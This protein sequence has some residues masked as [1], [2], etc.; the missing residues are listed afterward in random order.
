MVFKNELL[1]KSGLW[2]LAFRMAVQENSRPRVHGWVVWVASVTSRTLWKCR[3]VTPSGRP[4]NTLDCLL[5]HSGVSHS[6]S[7]LQC[8]QG[9]PAVLWRGPWGEGHVC[10]PLANSTT[11]PAKW[12]G[13][14]GR[15]SFS[16]IKCQPVFWLL[17]ERPWARTP[18]KLLSNSWPTET[19]WGNKYLLLF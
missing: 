5:A 7:Q 18:T 10:W 16:P 1:S 2:E 12:T 4:Q 8:C 3:W 13:H 11:L 19:E 15:R 9:A 14:L 6:G 17:Y